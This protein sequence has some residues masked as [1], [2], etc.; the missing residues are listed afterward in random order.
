MA[1]KL[2]NDASVKAIADAIRAKNGKTDTYT[3]AE[4]AGAINDIPAGQSVN[5]V[6]TNYSIDNQAI[7]DFD[8]NVV[9][10][11]DYSTTQMGT[12]DHPTS[13]TKLGQPTGTTP[14]NIVAGDMILSDIN[15]GTSWAHNVTANEPIYNVYPNGVC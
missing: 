13:Y 5:N 10:T 15:M 3:V 8:D 7:K 6:I 14:S 12:Y 2:Y 11:S 9:Y 4:M 1:N